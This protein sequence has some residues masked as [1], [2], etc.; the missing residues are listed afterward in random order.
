MCAGQSK[1]SECEDPLHLHF[2]FLT[3]S[4]SFSELCINFSIF[5]TYDILSLAILR[6]PD[7]PNWKSPRCF[8]ALSLVKGCAVGTISLPPMCMV[9]L[10][11]QNYRNTAFLKRKQ[12]GSFCTDIFNIHIKL[13]FIQCIVVCEILCTRSISE[14]LHC[15][16]AGKFDFRSSQ[17]I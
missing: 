9:C 3:S 7:I 15:T 17:K 16:Q 11:L 6:S 1:L 10:N 8:L 5:L 14:L 12:F 2:K 4:L 13:Y